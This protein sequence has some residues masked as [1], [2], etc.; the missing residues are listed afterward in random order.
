MI[1]YQIQIK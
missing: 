1:Y